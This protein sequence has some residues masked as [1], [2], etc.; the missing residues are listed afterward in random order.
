MKEGNRERTP[1]LEAED[2]EEEF[3]AEGRR[4]ASK[5]DCM[6]E[7]RSFRQQEEGQNAEETLGTTNKKYLRRT[8]PLVPPFF[9]FFVR[10]GCE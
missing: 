2:E 6:S 9:Q 5:I 1:E 10:S 3:R 7:Q 4:R 8:R